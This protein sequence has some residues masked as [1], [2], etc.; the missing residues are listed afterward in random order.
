ML[1]TSLN[2]RYHK[3]GCVSPSQ[4][5]ARSVVLPGTD[6]VI[7][8]PLC[9]VTDSCYPKAAAELMITPSVR[10]IF[11]AD[12][13]QECSTVDFTIKSSALAAPARY[14]M[15]GIKQF[16]ESSSIPLPANWFTTWPSEIEANYVALEVVCESNRVTTYTQEATISAVDVISN[17]GG[18]TGLWIGVSF[19]SLMEIAEMLYRLIRYQC[20]DARRKLLNRT[21]K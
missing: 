17:A 2:L 6:T 1:L 16:V 18:Q 14:L 8:A 11:C 19:L 20:Y 15:A 10:T 21:P 12:C 3:C 9:N 7:L 4:W 5:A 13:Q